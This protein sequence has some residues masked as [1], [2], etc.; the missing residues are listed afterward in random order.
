MN[1]SKE[2]I[3]TSGRSLYHTV[4][5]LFFFSGLCAL[6]YQ[7]IWVK[8]AGVVFGVAPFAISTVLSA[9]MAG[10]TLGSL[11]FG[12]AAD[13]SKNPLRLFGL[14]E[15]GI[16][17]FA[18][19]FPFLLSK[20]VNSYAY[21]YLH[22]H[23][24]FYTFSL[25]RFLM[26]FSLLL[27]PTFLMGGTLPVLSKSF[28]RDLRIL[29]RRV[30]TLYSV[31]NLGAAT[32][33]FLTGFFLIRLLG[34][35]STIF[36]AAGI[37]IATGISGLILSRSLPKLRRNMASVEK[38]SR[39]ANSIPN[40]VEGVETKRNN[41]FLVYLLVGVFTFGGFASL[42]YEV[43]W[44]RILSASI[45]SN[46]VY[47]FSTVVITFIAGLALG[48]FLYARLLDRAGKRVTIFGLVHAGIG[49]SA[50]FLLPVFARTPHIIGRISPVFFGTSPSWSMC[51]ASE[52]ILAFLL[53]IIP[54][55]LMGMT[56]PIMTKIYAGTLDKLGRKIGEINGLDA[57]GP[58]FGAFAGG[59]LFI[60]WLGMQKSV[61]IISF[62]NIAMGGVVLAFSP[63]I[64]RKMKWIFVSLLVVIALLGGLMVPLDYSFWRKGRLHAESLLYYREDPAATVVVR[65]YP[66]GGR[67]NRVIEVDGT[68]VAGTDYMLRSTQKLQGH[69]PLL[70][71][72]DPKKVLIVGLGSGG[73]TWSVSRHDVERIQVV[74]L[75]P[76]VAEA[77]ANHFTEVNHGVLHDTRVNLKI[78][79]G[80]NFVLTTQEKYDVILTESIHPIYAGNGN[81][82]SLE[83]FRS[84]RQKLAENGVMSV[85]IPLWGL[86][87]RDLKMIIRTFLGV[88]PHS[89]LWYAANSLN[90]QVYLIGGRN[91]LGIDFRAIRS[92]MSREAIDRDLREI[93]LNDPFLLLSAL[94]MGKE[95]LLEYTEGAQINSDDHPRLE[96]FDY[97]YLEFFPAESFHIRT[98]YENLR[99]I[100]KHKDEITPFLTNLGD[101]P[102]SQ[103]IRRRLSLYT[104]SAGHTIEGIIHALRGDTKQAIQK[105]GKAFE[106]NPQDKSAKRLLRHFLEYHYVN[107]GN[108][109]QYAGHIEEATVSYQKA[110]EVN[111]D[112]T[113]ALYNLAL[114]YLRKGMT[115]EAE[116]VLRRALQI[117][118]GMNKAS[119]MLN[120]LKHPER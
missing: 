103:E 113:I 117:D 112:S 97:P 61:L 98:V 84:C 37:N 4:L 17:G 14:M 31:N 19:I 90:R 11:F 78:A 107:K 96:F 54:T 24:S 95:S 34:L 80:R 114:I 39:G 33:C 110:L 68:D 87:E 9:F 106:T 40:P 67:L 102:E 60:P 89:S 59:F 81:L 93:R 64:Q 86:P 108:E 85:W 53:M 71:H 76:S 13:R 66:Q 111:P 57:A 115:K 56:F 92:R 42:V 119:E 23:T 30:G 26:V 21:V 51:I 43:L 25:S 36:L 109:M 105:F 18:L 120:R 101:D 100:L 48:S 27:I 41:P 28:I 3:G 10:L 77:A 29:G 55:T 69:L 49:V 83:Y 50:L 35:K 116:T 20:V 75:V 94:M 15:M 46:S 16:G 82:Y 52:F 62:L 5:V 72:K 6:T 65:E 63:D 8:M 32:G 38:N 2:E 99:S 70:I 12:R 73:T 79:D 118:P 1:S 74:E 88:F 104:E 45:L 44:T 91:K 47:S 22:F 58:M 7:V